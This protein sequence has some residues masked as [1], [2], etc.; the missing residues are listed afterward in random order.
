MIFMSQSG[1][2]DPSRQAAFRL[3]LVGARFERLAEAFVARLH[4]ILYL[5][6]QV[7]ACAHDAGRLRGPATRATSKIPRFDLQER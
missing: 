7:I 3:E 2:T 5:R 4:Q 1:L 6:P